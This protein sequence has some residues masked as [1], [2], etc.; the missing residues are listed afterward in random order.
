MYSNRLL[1]EINAHTPAEAQV[2]ANLGTQ[3]IGVIQSLA[4]LGS[5][6]VVGRFKR[7]PI[8]IWGALLI[9]LCL[10]GAAVSIKLHSGPFCVFFAT[11]INSLYQLSYGTVHWVMLPEILN[12][13]QFGLVCTAHY[14]NGIIISLDT[15]FLVKVLGPAGLCFYYATITFLGMFFV[16]S[17]VKETS[18]LTDRQKK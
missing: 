18:G 6:L 2:P 13:Q 3:V 7:K 4:G 8:F 10:L 11:A 12:D 15:E 5:F 1:T 14:V 16:I 9:S 17:V